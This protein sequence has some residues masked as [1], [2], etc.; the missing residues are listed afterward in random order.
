[1]MSNL[2]QG[3]ATGSRHLSG[4]NEKFSADELGALESSIGYSYL[5]ECEDVSTAFFRTSLD[6]LLSKH[7]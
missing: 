3:D 6:K 5:S 4:Y 1:M 7:D 2:R